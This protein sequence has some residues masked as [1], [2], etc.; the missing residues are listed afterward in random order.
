MSTKTLCL[1]YGLTPPPPRFPLQYQVFEHPA[2]AGLDYSKDR[3]CGPVKNPQRRP[4]VNAG[5][6]WDPL[7]VW[8]QSVSV[9]LF[10][11]DRYLHFGY[12]NLEIFEPI[13]LSWITFLRPV[14][15]TG[16]WMPGII[17]K[18][19]FFC[20]WPSTLNL[21]LLQTDVIAGKQ[22]SMQ[23]TVAWKGQTFVCHLVK[24]LW[25]QFLYLCC[26]ALALSTGQRQRS[27]RE[28][29]AMRRWTSSGNWSATC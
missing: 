9:Q 7:P 26:R 19:M 18:H 17:E 15:I 14:S 8:T 10:C 1:T 3:R 16:S 27:W 25:I 5:G 22:V 23:R 24:F 6:D 2:W 13:K 12:S 4:L 11:V 29:T 21:N 28:S 20:L